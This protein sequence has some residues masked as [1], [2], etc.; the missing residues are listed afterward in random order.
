MQISSFYFLF[1]DKRE[2]TEGFVS[3]CFLKFIFKS[4]KQET[5]LKKISFRE[6]GR[7]MSSFRLLKTVK[8]ILQK[9]KTVFKSFA[10]F[11]SIPSPTHSH[12][13]HGLTYPTAP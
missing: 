5:V 8:I 2:K 12:R 7:S 3:P 11:I 9:K 1:P 10:L 4:E 13:F 6:Y